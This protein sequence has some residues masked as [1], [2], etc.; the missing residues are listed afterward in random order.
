VG[1]NHL[2]F[3]SEMPHGGFKESGYGNDLSVFA[4]E[5]YTRIKHAMLRIAD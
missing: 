4:L 5:D 3:Q 2:P 1:N